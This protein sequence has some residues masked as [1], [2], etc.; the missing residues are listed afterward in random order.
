MV[1]SYIPGPVLSKNRYTIWLNGSTIRAACKPLN[2]HFYLIN[3]NRPIFFVKMAKIIFS[4]IFT[5]F[6]VYISGRRCYIVW[7][8][9]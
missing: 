9:M 5:L 7:Y 2:G 6:P 3:K 8:T 4:L 1:G